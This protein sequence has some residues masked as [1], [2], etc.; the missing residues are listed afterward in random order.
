MKGAKSFNLEKKKKKVRISK[1]DTSERLTA[2]LDKEQ[3]IML[4][5]WIS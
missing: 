4:R 5:V 1:G 3:E 2:M